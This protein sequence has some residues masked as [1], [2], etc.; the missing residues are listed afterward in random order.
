MVNFKKKCLSNNLKDLS[1]KAEKIKCIGS[2]K[3]FMGLNKLHELEC[4]SVRNPIV[5]A[6]A[7][8]KDD[9]GTS[10]DA[11]KFKQV[12]GSLMYLTVTRSYLMFGGGKTEITAYSDNNYVGDFDDRRS[13]SGVVFILGP[14]VVSWTSKKQSVVSLSTIEAE[15]IAATAC[16][17]DAFDFIE[18]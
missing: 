14:G 5:S 13:T 17:V 7:L 3:L 2:R 1:K 9:E 12:V 11:T 18:F 8:S 4:N 16:V 6:T 15:Y 10:V